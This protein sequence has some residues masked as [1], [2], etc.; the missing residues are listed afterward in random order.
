MT[1]HMVLSTLHTNSAIGAVTRMLDLG[2]DPAV[3]AT[4]LTMVD[5]PA[6]GEA[7]LQRMRE[8]YEPGETVRHR[9][10]LFGDHVPV[11]RGRGCPACGGTG[12]AAA[13]ASTRSTGRRTPSGR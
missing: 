1:G 2:I 9:A 13:S 8:E 11:F 3:L 4:S 10:G 7:H 5:R 12:S 6:A